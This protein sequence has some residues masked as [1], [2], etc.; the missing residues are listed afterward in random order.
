[1]RELIEQVRREPDR[2]LVGW[3]GVG[4]TL[5]GLAVAIDAL[6]EASRAVP[7]AGLL[8]W[9]DRL[10][11]GLWEFRIER[12]AWFTVGLFVLWW[13]IAQ[14]ARLGG[15]ASL[16]ARVAGGLAVGFALLA[17]AVL[18]GSTLVALRGSVG[19]LEI[20]SRERVL[21]WL[22]QVSTAVGAG[23][24]WALL[25]VRLPDAAEAAAGREQEAADAAEAA[26]NEAE[27]AESEPLTAP[28][29]FEQAPVW[30]L[31]DAEPEP[32]PQPVPVPA[33]APEP[34][35][36]PEP[37]PVAAAVSTPAAHETAALRAHRLYQERL[38]YSPRSQEARD[39]VEKVA[40]AEREGRAAEAHNLLEQL[41]AL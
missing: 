12:A 16:L 40:T 22:L 3:A 39:L 7:G 28:P 23:L 37:E 38:A 26:W 32:T 10:Q 27:R 19:P 25:A 30:A 31:T 36:E 4:M 15:R 24:V 9:Y 5:L 6:V 20:S 14:R 41:A 21:T 17:A 34:E 1:V 35:P 18:L 8:P 33:P 29:S 13:A 11:I 2:E